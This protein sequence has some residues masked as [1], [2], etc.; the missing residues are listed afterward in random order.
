[1]QVSKAS[2]AGNP[3]IGLFARATDKLCVA[4]VSASHKLITALDTLGV[5]VMKTT[6]GGFSMAG[7]CL[8]MNS[9]G[10]V[11]PSFC[12]KEEVDAL[13][14]R[15]LEVLQL[16]GAFS[17]AGNNIAANDYGCVA[18]PEMP[19]KLLT[20][21]ADCLGVEAVPKRGAGYLTSG[22]AGLATNR[23]FLA[24]NRASEAELKELAS[25]LKVP[26]ENCTLCMGVPFVSLCAIANSQGAVLGEATTGFESGRAAQG[27]SL[28][29]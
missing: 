8:A 5:P 29:G 26:G 6:F 11:V 13:K 22:S 19:R 14:S 4:D 21:I 24:H 28:L 3:Y 12:S 16:S 15:D 18:N 1:M 10:A 25:I 23:G 17:A 27:L 9:R 20:R 2:N 7:I